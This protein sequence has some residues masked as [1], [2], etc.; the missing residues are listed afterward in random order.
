[1]TSGTRSRRLDGGNEENS[2]RV[3]EVVPIVYLARHGETAWTLSGQY[4]GLAGLSLTKRGERNA[5]R[6][7]ERLRGGEICAP[8]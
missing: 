7:E 2:E 4:T 3:N 6:L 1:M 5:R 8:F